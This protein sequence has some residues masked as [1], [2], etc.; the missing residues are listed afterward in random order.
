MA[1]LQ[2][3]Q[4]SARQDRPEAIREAAQQFE[5]LFLHRLVKGMRDTVPTSDLTNSKQTEFY[6]SLLDQQ[7]S[8][9]MAERGIG[10]ADQL[11]AQLEAEGT[12]R[13]ARNDFSRPSPAVSE[14]S[15]SAEEPASLIA[16]I[17]RGTPQPLTNPVPASATRNEGA[18]QAGGESSFAG[19]AQAG[20]S[21]DQPQRFLDAFGGRATGPLVGGSPDD[22]DQVTAGGLK[23]GQGDASASLLQ[24]W[25]RPTGER[26]AS[27]GSVG[28][29]LFS[30]LGK[31]SEPATDV[32]AEHVQAFL[33]P[34]AGPAQAASRR[35]GVPAEL[36]LAQAA[37]ETGWGQY[38]ILTPEGQNSHNL[39][40]IKAGSQWQ[41]P[42]AEVTTH[43]HIEGQRVRLR[44]RFRVYESF[45]AAF[46]DYASLI[47]ESPRY[48]AVTTAPNAEHAARELQAGG[49]ATDPAYADKLISIM[50]SLGPVVSQASRSPI[51]F[52]Y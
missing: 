10:L 34:L 33:E 11:V 4:Q 41:G 9:T 49:Y 30:G 20:A 1:G 12:A 42:T 3:L 43:E 51:F 38:Q 40:G 36:I 15:A 17:P 23:N 25:R 28:V 46:T 5:A 50:E 31:H 24:G 13:S 48:N 8:Q 45:E 21:A 16:G 52:S 26:P 39:F 2:R 37:L 19:S 6:Q 32:L 27:S 22:S 47:S 7:W 35:T 14:A 29:G 44:D 18:T